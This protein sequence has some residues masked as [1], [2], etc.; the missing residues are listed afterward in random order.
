M[1]NISKINIL[2][3]I[4]DNIKNTQTPII[5]LD[6]NIVIIKWYYISKLFNKFI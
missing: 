2:C 3:N 5:I 1:V 6:N 4:G